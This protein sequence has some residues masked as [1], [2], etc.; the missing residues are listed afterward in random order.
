MERVLERRQALEILGGFGIVLATGCD[1]SSNGGATPDAGGTGGAGGE[2]S[3]AE[4]SV[5]AD[6]ASGDSCAGQ[7]ASC[8]RI[9]AETSGPYPDTLGMIGN[10]TYKRADVRED[11]TGVS[12]TLVLIIVDASNSC[13]A[14]ADAN[15]EIWHCDKDGIYSEYSNSM[16]AGSTSTTYLRGW[17]TTDSDGKVTFTTIFPGWYTPRATHVHVEVFNGTT[18]KFTTQLGFPDDV[19]S[20]VYALSTYKNGQAN[21]TTNDTD[22]VFGGTDSGGSGD[23]DGGGHTYQIATVCGDATS[24]YTATLQVAIT[25][26]SS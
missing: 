20:A 21:A 9:P 23:G 13:A 10:T 1:S 11:R 12:L 24:G 3:A 25:G 8:H 22:Q 15:V 5:A 14:I 18:L 4:T 19:N 17:Q 2:A 16:N 26:Y 7:Q 6:G